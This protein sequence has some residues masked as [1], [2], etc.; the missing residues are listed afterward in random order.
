MGYS[1]YVQ[2][3]KPSL[4]AGTEKNNRNFST[5]LGHILSHK[6]HSKPAFHKG[7]QFARSATLRTP[8]EVPA[9]QM[10]YLQ[11]HVR[12]PSP[13]TGTKKVMAIFVRCLTTSSHTKYIPS[14]RSTREFDPLALQRSERLAKSRRSERNRTNHFPLLRAFPKLRLKATFK[15]CLYF[16]RLMYKPAFHMGG[17]SARSPTL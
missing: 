14:P 15:K 17:Q 11:V 16:A 5:H 9:Q 4:L 8:R 6:R 13:F 2:G 1:I 3:Y 10:G 12:K 7:S